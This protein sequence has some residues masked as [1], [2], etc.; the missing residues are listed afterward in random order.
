MFHEGKNITLVRDRAPLQAWCFPK[1]T[2]WERF[3]ELVPGHHP[4][5]TM[6]VLA[7][8]QHSACSGPTG[9]QPSGRDVWRR[10]PPRSTNGTPRLLCFFGAYF[11]P[12]TAPSPSQPAP[13]YAEAATVLVWRSALCLL[14]VRVRSSS[15]AQKQIHPQT[16]QPN[17]RPTTQALIGRPA[18]RPL[19]EDVSL[20]IARSF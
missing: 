17:T 14:I 9:D 19:S 1:L 4:K 13:E 7:H 12:C 10:S 20:I 15:I 8:V 5:I 11:Q 16:R 2:A 18:A 3:E 6:L